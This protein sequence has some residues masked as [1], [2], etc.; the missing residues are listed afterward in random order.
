MLVHVAELKASDVKL[1]V[2]FQGGYCPKIIIYVDNFIM[3]LI[4]D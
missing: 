1:F 3:C 2:V 4:D